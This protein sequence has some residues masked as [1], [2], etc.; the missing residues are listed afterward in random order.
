MSSL[1][2]Q[3]VYGIVNRLDGAVCERFF[4]P[5]GEEPIRTLESR[6]RLS[7]FDIVAFSVSFENDYVELVRL[8]RVAGLPLLAAERGAPHPLIMAGGVACF[9]NPEPVAPFLDCI[10]LG[11]AEAVLPA[12][13]EG[14]RPGPDRADTL[15][16]LARE[17]PGVYV[18]GL[19]R[20]AHH[21]DGTLSALA[22]A[23]DAPP[24]IRRALVA[25]LDATET[26]TVVT[27]GDGPFSAEVL[28]EVGRGCP[29]G[30]RF[31]SA[32][33]VY[34]PPRF[35]SPGAIEAQVRESLPRSRRIGL[36][37]AA[38]SDLPGLDALCSRLEGGGLRL[39]FSSLRADALTPELVRALRTNRTRT[40]TIA[41][42]AGSER[43]RRVINKGLEEADILAAVERLVTG[44]IPNLKLYFIVGL[45][46]ETDE[47]VQAIVTLTGRIRSAFV[48][49]SRPRG[50]IGSLS[51]SVTPFVP[52]PFTPF[53]WSPMAPEAA[54]RRIL[55]RLR[56]DLDRMPNVRCRTEP[57]DGAR[58]QAL[59]SRGDRR[60]APVL[61]EVSRTGAPWPRAL[62]EAGIDPDFYLHRHRGREEL[63]PWDHIDNR[64]SKAF[65]WREY[66]L[67]LEAR[68]TPPCPMGDCRI[69][70]ACTG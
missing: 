14:Y 1:G 56:R 34:R 51:V 62:R 46:T 44:G 47:D 59:L 26:R 7:D 24:R 68:T 37:G 54:L 40:A 39:A 48:D 65:L 49:A 64:I 17:L 52:K 58:L 12:F 31:C 55:S 21:P 27:T 53:Q 15:L 29:H 41:P 38:V 60:L 42:E 20:A 9:L 6:R 70:G 25:D 18:P 16:R 36:V 22:P 33:F 57:L 13:L 69:C 8:I 61:R 35:R 66:R 10:L 67:A 4:A 11:E 23:P 2:F 32:G 3:A 43:M 45:P 30:C 5:E 50:R 19:Y 63:L 28:V